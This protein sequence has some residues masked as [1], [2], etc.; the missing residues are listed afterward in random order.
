MT[1]ADK[2]LL[3]TIALTGVAATWTD[4]RRRVV[5]NR[6]VAAVALALLALDVWRVHGVP[7][8]SLAAA[9]GVL[10]LLGTLSA[11]D[12]FGWGDAKLAAALALA[13]DW[14]YAAALLLWMGLIGGAMAFAWAAPDAWRA[15][16]VTMGTRSVAM[17]RVA[18]REGLRRRFPYA[19]AVAAG[20]IVALWL[21][22]AV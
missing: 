19:P 13:G 20:A 2:I 14:R 18:I 11:L 15:V 5:P 3:A 8:G 9:A 6:L 4:L 16:Q 1:H 12:L 7:W 22:P 21:Q 17:A 10:A